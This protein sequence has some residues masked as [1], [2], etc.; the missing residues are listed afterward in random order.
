[1]AEL[2]EMHAVPDGEML[3]FVDHLKLPAGT[4]YQRQQAQAVEACAV[5]RQHFEPTRQG[6]VITG[7]SPSNAYA[8]FVWFRVIG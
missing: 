4:E 3:A 8:M 7:H 2:V 5:V 1:M 6:V